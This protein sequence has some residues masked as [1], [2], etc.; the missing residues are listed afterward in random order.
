MNHFAKGVVGAPTTFGG[1]SRSELMSR[2][3]SAGNLSTEI[4]LARLL[5]NHRLCG[6]RRRSSLPG[7]PDFIWSQAKV[8]LFVDGCFWHG[9]NC[10]RNLKPITNEGYWDYK[11][12]KNIARDKRVTRV[13][14]KKGWVVVRIWECRLEKDPERCLRR[15]GSKLRT[16]QKQRAVS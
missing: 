13:L 16:E 12:R 14:R 2:V 7:K 6:W 15:I 1:L 10:G 5:R 3:R 9:H 11:I 8:A 4:K